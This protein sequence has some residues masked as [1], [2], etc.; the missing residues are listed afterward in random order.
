MIVPTSTVIVGAGPAGLLLAL[1]LLSSQHSQPYHITLLEKGDDPRYVISGTAGGATKVFRTYPIALKPRGMQAIRHVPGLEHALEQHGTW[2]DG[3]IMHGKKQDRLIPQE[4]SVLNIDRISLVVALLNHLTQ[5]IMEQEDDKGTTTKR[6]RV[7]IQFDSSVE[8]VDLNARTLR[9]VHTKN[10]DTKIVMTTQL[11]FD[12]LIAADGARSRIRQILSDQGLL[13]F[14]LKYVP[15]EYKSIYLSTT[16]IDG[17]MHLLRDKVHV[18]MSPINPGVRVICGPI[19]SMG[20]QQDPKLGG[21]LIFPRGQDPLQDLT[22]G[23]EIS[24]RLADLFPGR[25]STLASFL[26]AAET[27]R[28]C[29]ASASKIPSVRCNQLYVYYPPSSL[30]TTMS[31]NAKNT[32]NP[33]TVL[34]LGDAAHAVSASLGEGCNSALQ[35]A[36]LFANH[37]DVVQAEKKDEINDSNEIWTLAVKGFAEQRLPEAHAIE[38]LSFYANPTTKW[39]RTQF[40]LRLMVRN[41]LLNKLRLPKAWVNWFI[42]PLPM[43]LLRGEVIPAYTD[44]LRQSKWWVDRIRSSYDTIE[45]EMPS[46]QVGMTMKTKVI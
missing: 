4:S 41:L 30:T 16:S 17:T 25:S 33:T 19:R 29:G 3:S 42:R 13:E 27:Q 12:H 34:L 22:D 18:W 43:E 35:D 9:V 26:T 44:V 2:V 32:N 28:L 1:Y 40:I 20:D 5:R 23:Q 7:T 36:Y 24:Q 38:E 31:T 45:K 37:L 10:D 11:H 21:A 14:Q 39:L 8:D 6:N 15:D 46:S